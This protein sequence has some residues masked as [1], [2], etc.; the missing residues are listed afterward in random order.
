MKLVHN[1]GVCD[2]ES[3][4]KPRDYDEWL[5]ILKYCHDTAFQQK[6]PIFVGCEVDE[7]WRTYSD[8]SR[9]W[10]CYHPLPFAGD[11][12]EAEQKEPIRYV[13]DKDLLFDG[14]K[15]YGPDTCCLL[16]REMSYFFTD[17][18]VN[19]DQECV[20][21]DKNKQAFVAV[22]R[23]RGKQRFVRSFDNRKDALGAW[24]YAKG[25]LA[26]K[27][28]AKHRSDLPESVANRFREKARRFTDIV[29]PRLSEEQL[30][31]IVKLTS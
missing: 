10:T 9:W 1:W 17:G 18:K 5:R 29:P 24:E 22:V 20:R 6:N 7:R 27:L 3:L 8:F 28:L 26:K 4:P 16:P 15:L 11:P 31:M 21:F 14:N 23:V 13:V 25:L 12:T 19:A 2:D 30:K